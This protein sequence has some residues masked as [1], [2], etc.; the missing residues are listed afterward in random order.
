MN[1]VLKYKGQII[2]GWQD[3]TIKDY[4]H[5]ILIYSNIKFHTTVKNK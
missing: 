5:Y 4:H 1:I 2:K 3:F